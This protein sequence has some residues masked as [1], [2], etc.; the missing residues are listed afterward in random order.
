MY[1]V[2]EKDGQVVACHHALSTPEKYNS[3]VLIPAL[4]EI[5]QQH[6]LRPDEVDMI[7]VNNGPGS[8]TG[9]R[10]GA[11]M[12]RTIG[13]FLD[14][15]V[16]PVTSLEIYA[17]A[18]NINKDK[19]VILDA[20]RN[21]WYTGYYASDNSVIEEPQLDTNMYVLE[22]LTGLNAQIIT[23]KPLAEVLKDFNPLF[24]EDLQ[25][26]FGLIL[27]ELAKKI[28]SQTTNFKT[29]FAWHH[30]KPTYLQTP[31]ITMPKKKSY[32]H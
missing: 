27:T 7:A 15:P 1:L 29:D 10:A 2:V 11:V 31:S 12:A 18:C 17:N 28:V 4:L 30:L 25:K 13:Q 23:E 6:N 14:V 19:F 21:K 9:I 5:F 16:V 8:F 26:D 22:K 24:I 3:A 32:L 20:R